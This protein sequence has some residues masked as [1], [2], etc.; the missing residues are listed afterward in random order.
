MKTL[1]TVYDEEIR[2]AITVL[3]KLLQASELSS[4]FS[5]AAEAMIECCRNKKIIFIFGNGGSAADAQHFAAELVGRF[6]VERHALPGMALSTDSSALTAISNDYG[7][8]SVFSRQLSG[9]GSTGC[10]AVGISTSGNSKNILDGLKQ[11]K[12][13][14]MSTILMRGALPGT[15]DDFAD[16]ILSA[17]SS[18]TSRIQEVH[19]LW[20]HVL[21]GMIE[22]SL[23]L[24]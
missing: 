11:A 16:I 13:M 12:S 5:R 14:S 19:G 23:Q 20:I 21:C 15:C 9:L 10:V 3:S 1:E 7:F 17:P 2:E 24:S 6:E 18:R 4:E 22:R 8:Q